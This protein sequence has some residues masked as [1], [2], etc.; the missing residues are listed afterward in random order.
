MSSEEQWVRLRRERDATYPEDSVTSEF[1]GRFDTEKEALD[2]CGPRVWTQV[3]DSGVEVCYT[4]YQEEPE[5][6]ELQEEETAPQEEE[7]QVSVTAPSVPR[8]PLLWQAS[9]SLSRYRPV[10]FGGF[11]CPVAVASCMTPLERLVARR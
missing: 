4:V 11:R 2:G 3:G 8:R 10:Q 5:E 7:S 1:E 6:E 9:V